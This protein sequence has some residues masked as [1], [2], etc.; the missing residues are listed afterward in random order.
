MPKGGLLCPPF[1]HVPVACRLSPP[2]L[3]RRPPH[4]IRLFLSCPSYKK[5]LPFVS[6][7]KAERKRLTYADVC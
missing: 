5:A 4:I 1:A 7:P 3:M 6:M 2:C